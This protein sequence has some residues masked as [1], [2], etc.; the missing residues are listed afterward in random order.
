VCSPGAG[1]PRNR[2][3][4]SDQAQAIGEI[5]RR[6][7]AGDLDQAIVLANATLRKAFAD[8]DP[9]TAGTVLDLIG[10]IAARKGSLIDARRAYVAAYDMYRNLGS[11]LGM[12]NVDLSLGN[13]CRRERESGTARTHFEKAL[14][15][16]A[17]AG[18]EVGQGQAHLNLGI[19]A[20]TEN[21][22]PDAAQHFKMALQ[23]FEEAN[24]QHDLAHVR[25]QAAVLAVACGADD[26]GDGLDAAMRAYIAVG[27]HLGAGNAHLAMAQNAMGRRDL[28]VAERHLND[29][30]RLFERTQARLGETEVRET[31]GELLRLAEAAL[32]AASGASSTTELAELGALVARTR[33]VLAEESGAAA[34]RRL[35]EAS[36]Q[37]IMQAY[38]QVGP[39]ARSEILVVCVADTAN[40]HRARAAVSALY[41]SATG[42]HVFVRTP[43]EIVE[44]CGGL[45]A[46]NLQELDRARSGVLNIAILAHGGAL[47]ISTF[48]NPLTN[49]V[50]MV[51]MGSRPPP[52]PQA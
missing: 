16:Y 52:R 29:A 26:T 47:C 36:F 35:L 30:Q 34:R 21:R 38:A 43:Q 31:R 1:E 37:G 18:G 12:A 33:D 9:V 44:A 39:R 2:K 46:E 32:R 3:L 41:G 24:S 6:L 23:L 4:M 15:G 5:R 22:V 8:Q 40:D 10:D 20:R 25:F 48:F 17:R 13:L 49:D 50:V 11:E 51:P 42:V 45:P 14:A 19:L 28:Q 7:F 27:D